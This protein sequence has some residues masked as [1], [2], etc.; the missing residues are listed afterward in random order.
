MKQTKLSNCILLREVENPLI[1]Q[2]IV[3]LKDE[4]ISSEDEAVEVS[5]MMVNN[6]MKR[7]RPRHKSK[8]KNI[9]FTLGGIVLGIAIGIFI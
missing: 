2:I 1:S 8:N 6:C 5:R 3:M 7:Y 9:L 4:A